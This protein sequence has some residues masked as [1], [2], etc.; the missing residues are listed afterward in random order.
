MT[1]TIFSQ[2]A[3]IIPTKDG[4]LSIRML[5]HASLAMEYQGYHIYIDPW[6]KQADFSVMPKADLI[7]LTH[8][9]QDHLDEAAIKTLS[10]EKTQ[11]VGTAT[12]KSQVKNTKA[13]ANGEH[14]VWHSITIDAIPAYN[15]TP[16]RE[17]YHPKGRDNGYL[18]SF[19][20]TKVYVAG[21]TEDTPEMKQ[22]RNIHVAFLP[23]N[24][25]YTMTPEQVNASV[26]AFKPDILYPYHMG[27]TD[28][29]LLKKLMKDNTRTKIRVVR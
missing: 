28:P 15:T 7:L 4:N 10:N 8:Q 29:A 16:G 11:I 5:G 21:D 14:M 12:V 26:V 19:S 22:L 17:Q 20:G 3:E 9:H 23:M 24:Q 13:L 25:P 2:Q 27:D 6:S 1:T 18:L